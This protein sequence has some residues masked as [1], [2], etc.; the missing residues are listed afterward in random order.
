MCELHV[1]CHNV[2]YLTSLLIKSIS[3]FLSFKVH[4][5]ISNRNYIKLTE[6]IEVLLQPIKQMLKTK[7]TQIFSLSYFIES[8]FEI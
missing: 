8:V 5:V 2:Q 1:L 3:S 4:G 6:K 7:K